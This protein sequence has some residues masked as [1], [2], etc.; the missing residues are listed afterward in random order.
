VLCEA[1]ARSPR[2]RPPR[3]ARRVRPLPPI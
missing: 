3:N 1:V 2:R